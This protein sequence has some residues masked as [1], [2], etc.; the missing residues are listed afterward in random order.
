MTWSCPAI[1][2]SVSIYPDGKIRPCC[3]TAAEYSKPISEISNPNRFADLKTEHI[4]A[5]CRACE[6]KG[7]KTYRDWFNEYS[8]SFDGLQ[9]VDFRH[10][11]QCN[12]KCRYC[13]PHFS[14]QWARELSYP[15]PLMTAQIDQYY[16]ILLSDNL[17]DLYWCGGEPLIISDHYDVLQK[18]IDTEQSKDVTLR[19][20]T[21]LSVIQYKDK[22][23]IDMWK[24]FKS[25]SVTISLDAI[26]IPLNYIRSGSDWTKISSNIDQ[27]LHYQKNLP[28]LD[29][30]LAPT[31][32]M[33]NVWFLPELFQYAKDKK[34]PI[35]T[36]ILYGPD[37]LSLSA[38]CNEELKNLAREKLLE[39][40]DMILPGNWDELM[41]MLSNTEN[42][43]LF[44][45]ALRHI[46]LLDS[47]RKEKLFELLPFKK[48]AIELTLKN[49]EYE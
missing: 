41:R 47:I 4:P 48:F 14:N 15:N 8:R 33:L 13:H 21:N 26:G 16:D 6:P 37:Y 20:N 19:Y 5:A 1:D 29:L 9:F 40:K 12:L 10:S 23:I 27:L 22:N 17:R 43:Y 46:M 35:S 45:H 42:E 49:N 3:L 34:I 31:V 24:H 38:L 2:H 32:S 30:K 7:K 25:V 18:L 28:N 11:N 44:N 36:N 39:V